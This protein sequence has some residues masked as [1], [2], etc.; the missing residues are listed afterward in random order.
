MLLTS[1]ILFGTVSL[2][3]AQH[4]LIEFNNTR[5][6]GPDGPWIPITLRPGYPLQ[7][8]DF[9]PTF[10]AST[11]WFV[12]SL[13]CATSNQ[14]CLES[15]QNYYDSTAFSAI[16]NP[17]LSEM[18]NSSAVSFDD[19]YG[20][21]GQ[22]LNATGSAGYWHEESIAISDLG[23]SNYYWAPSLSQVTSTLT[24]ALFP[25]GANY[26]PLSLFTLDPAELYLPNAPNNTATF[27]S[28]L[29]DM[30]SYTP[31]HINSMS[32]GMHIGSYAQKI[33]GSLVLGGYDQARIIGNP[34]TFSSSGVNLSSI[35]LGSSSGGFDWTTD[36]LDRDFLSTEGNN[37]TFKSLN[38]SLVSGA[39]Y[40]YLPSS[41]CSSL[42][43]VL[44]I[45]YN[46]DF[47]L[48]TWNTG[49]TSYSSMVSSPTYL[50]FTFTDSQ[51]IPLSVNIPF[52]LL[53]L[54]LDA[55]LVQKPTP[56]FPCSPNDSTF[57]L[58]RAFLQ[59]AFIGMNYNSS[60]FWLAQAPGPNIPAPGSAIKPIGVNDVALVPNPDGPSWEETWSEVWFPPNG[61]TTANSTSTPGVSGVPSPGNTSS[62]QLPAGAIAGIVVGLVAA[63]ILVFLF[64]MWHR[65]RRQRSSVSSDSTSV[66]STTQPW[67]SKSWFLSKLGLKKVP[68]PPEAPVY[69]EIKELDTRILP[70][71]IPAYAGLIEL[72][73]QGK[74][75]EIRGTPFTVRKK[76]KRRNGEEQKNRN[77]F[78]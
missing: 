57:G 51:N 23:N 76:T 33:D 2:A 13:N 34:G 20:V 28:M 38:V 55:P 36:L 10:N 52:A 64:I 58:G 70:A 62:S 63:T 5:P 77:W 21:T 15:A 35:S 43:S 11:N 65:R 32:W 53:N 73:G 41:V 66:G 50:N 16:N 6:I 19:I 4:Q 14:T 25:N 44:P 68:L 78:I 74:P 56:Y 27:V 75:A 67:F 17:L 45:S 26:V 48:Y 31:G 30:Y 59:G 42:A 39:P 12:A 46:A 37:S 60:T 22:L 24:N 61:S 54:T 29:N 40:L 18:K 71:E 49:N 72:P 1:S 3:I 69:G 8:I 9:Y 7:Y 47:N